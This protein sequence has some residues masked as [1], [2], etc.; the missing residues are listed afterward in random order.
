MN[1]AKTNRP[2][3]LNMLR[4]SRNIVYLGQGVSP[5]S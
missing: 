3:A 4:A 1:K 5:S 2:K